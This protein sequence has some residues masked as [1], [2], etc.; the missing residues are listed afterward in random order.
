MNYIK[1]AVDQETYDKVRSAL[2]LEPLTE[3]SQKGAE[4]T[5]KIRQNVQTTS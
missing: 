5:E 3:A 1:E 4:I 2:G